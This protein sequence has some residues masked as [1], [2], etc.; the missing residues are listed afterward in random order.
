M[1]AFLLLSTI[2]FPGNRSVVGLL[3]AGKGII[4][5]LYLLWRLRAY[6]GHR[7][8]IVAPIAWGALVVYAAVASSWS[9]FPISAWKLVG[10]MTGSLLIAFVFVRATKGGY[11][12]QNVLVPVTAGTLGL[13]FLCFTFEP[14]WTGEP[15]RFTSFLPA[16]GFA[17]FL[18]ALFCLSLCAQTL[19]RQT[20]IIVC[21]ALLAA[22]I[23]NGSRIWF[24]GILIA[25]VIALLISDVRAWIKFCTLGGLVILS[26]LLVWQ[27]GNIVERL[28]HGAPSN[29]IV[30]AIAAWYQGDSASQGLGTLNF[31]RT[32]VASAVER[33][34]EASL[35]DLVLG[36]GTSDA[37]VITGSLYKGYALYGDPNRML[38]NEWLRV[39]YEWGLIGF[40][41]WCLFI[42][43]IAV[44]AFEGIRNDPEGNSKPLFAYLLPFLIGLAGENF[45][46][47]A[48]SAMSTGFLL[49][50]ALASI[51]HRQAHGRG[52]QRMCMLSAE[53]R[54]NDARVFSRGA[55]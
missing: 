3:N 16:Q 38:H 55:V 30:A 12:S 42:G 53:R 54:Q 1:I 19:K 52:Y 28:G 25:A 18:G 21:T 29:R 10:H 32:I 46:A 35:S 24:L 17:S 27:S 49:L 44:F 48:G 5:P 23:A 2:D 4:V 7:N 8:V 47:G 31:R 26:S 39:L 51:S 37:A 6:S 14:N 20:R 22:L 50:I 34:K 45:L 41:F 36:H 9:T 15:G 43:S 13:A 11:L 40:L 33:I